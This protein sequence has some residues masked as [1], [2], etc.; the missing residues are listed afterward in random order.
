MTISQCYRYEAHHKVGL[1]FGL[2]MLVLS[3]FLMGALLYLLAEVH[4][5]QSSMGW[6]FL[7][8][9][10]TIFAGTVFLFILYKLWRSFNDFSMSIQEI[11]RYI[12]VFIYTCI[13]CP[14]SVPHAE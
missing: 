9:M 11:K 14:C 13:R 4:T 7:E 8:I 2:I 3:I 12:M 5:S 10:G 1:C 6:I